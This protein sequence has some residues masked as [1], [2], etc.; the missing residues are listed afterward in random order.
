MAHSVILAMD[1]SL[2]IFLYLLITFVLAN[3]P[4]LSERNFLF[5]KPGKDEK[6]GWFRWFE[7]VVFCLL[8]G[9]MGFGLEKKM[10]GTVAD[11]DWEFYVVTFCLFLVFALPG[12]IYRFDLRKLLLNR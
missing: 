3:L 10:M 1:S 12:F 4:W 2:P 5:F 11:Q 8:A 7:W 9:L 6:S